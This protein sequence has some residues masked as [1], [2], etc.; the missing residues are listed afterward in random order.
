MVEFI[1]S[2]RDGRGRL[3]QREKDEECD[4][5]SFEQFAIGIHTQGGLDWDF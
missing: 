4:N 3:Y 2:P 1:P 5:A